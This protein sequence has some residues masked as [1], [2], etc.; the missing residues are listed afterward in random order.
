MTQT[1]ERDDEDM[2][3]AQTRIVRRVRRLMLFSSLIMAAGILAVLG[4]IAYR[5]SAGTERGRPPDENASLPKGAR[6]LSTAVSDGRLAVT[7][8][9]A[10]A[11]EVRLF[12][13][14]TLEPRGRVTF[15]TEP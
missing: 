11:I 6:V 10:G 14:A 3:P 15:R 5:L 7:I 4:V 1:S 12:D 13:L 9:I 8:E 2:T